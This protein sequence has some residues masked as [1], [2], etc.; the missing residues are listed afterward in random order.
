MQVLRVRP[1]WVNRTRV[2]DL[3]GLCSSLC[4]VQYLH[5][6]LE[7]LLLELMQLLQLLDFDLLLP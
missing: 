3:S 1:L 5:L 7:Y 4:A 6:L 2:G